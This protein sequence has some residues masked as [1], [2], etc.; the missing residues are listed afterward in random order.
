MAEGVLSERDTITQTPNSL[1]HVEVL[2][3]TNFPVAR[4]YEQFTMKAG[5]SPGGNWKNI[6]PYGDQSTDGGRL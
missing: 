6:Q 3:G 4:P 2:A 1:R 5:Q